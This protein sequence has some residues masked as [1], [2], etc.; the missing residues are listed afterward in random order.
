MTQSAPPPG[1]TLAARI[2]QARARFVAMATTYGLGVFN[3]NFFKQAAMLL[4]VGAGQTELQ[5]YS[6]V[7]FTLPFILFAAPA[8]WLADRFAKRRVVIGSK[9]LELAAMV[10]GAAGIVTG[11]WWLIFIMLG[12]MGL[13]S[14]IFSPALNG[15]IPELYPSE[16]VT[17]ANAML[18]L[19]VTIAILAGVASA[20][21][22]LDRAGT[23]LWGVGLG[24]LTVA[25]VVVAVSLVGLLVSLGVPARPAA[26]PR[27]AFPWSGPLI[28]FRTLRDAAR[29]PL[30]ATTISASVFI[31]FLGSLE[32]LLINPLGMQQFGLGTA[33][34]SYL[35]A[36][37]LIGIGV[38]GVISARVAVGERWHRVIGPA[39]ALVAACM[40]ALAA[41]PALPEGARVAALFALVGGVGIAGGVFLIPV[42][43][44]IQVRP[45]AEKKGAVLAATN[46]GVFIGI[47]LSGL[48]SNALLAV[49]LPTAG[50]GLAG[51][52]TLLATGVLAAA[53][54]RAEGRP[55]LL[56]R[57]LTQL[58]RGLLRL[59]YRIR[60][61]GLEAVAARGEGPILFL[62]NH[63]ALI[64]PVIVMLEL[65]PRFAPR[66]LADRDQVDRFLVRR[67]ADRFGVRPMA[68][69]GRYGAAAREDV[70][71]A[72][73]ACAADL[74]A[75]RNLILYPAGRIYRSCREDLGG[76]SALETLLGSVPDVRVVLVRTR[77][78]WGSRFSR[79]WGRHPDMV[80]GMLHG[81]KVLLANA[82]FFAPRRPVRIE[83]HEPADLPRGADRTVLNRYLEGFYNTDATPNTYVP[84]Y[85]WERGGVRALPDP[86]P[87]RLTGTVADAP[88]A[89][90]EIVLRHLQELTGVAAIRPEDLLARDLGLDSLAQVD[91]AAWLEREFGHTVE[92][93][94]A[95][96]S[97]KDVILAACGQVTAAGPAELAPIPAGWFAG[98]SDGERITLPAGR[99][100]A[101]VFLAQARRAPGR[102]AIA[103]QTRGARTYRDL[104]TAVQVL[105]PAIAALPG[106]AV[107][108]MLPAS[109]G[110]AVLYLAT[111]FAGKTPVMVNWT[112]GPRQMAHSLDL[113]GVRRVLTAGRLV[114][115]VQAQG[116][117]LSAI[118]DRLVLLEEV[119]KSISLGAK[120][121]AA[122]RAR[123]G[124]HGLDRIVPQDPAVILFTSGSENLPKAVPLTHANILTNIRDVVSHFELA[125]GD[126]ALGILPPFHSFGLTVTTLLPLL[127]G[128]RVVYHSNPTEGADLARLIA[129]YQV[130]LLVG[131][132][133]FLNGIVRNADDAQLA[134]LRAVI[135][136]AEKCPDELFAEVARRWPGLNIVEGYGITECSPVVAA[137]DERAPRRG[138][139]GKPLPSVEHVVVDLETNARIPPGAGR[140]GMLLVRGPSV[141]GGYLGD[142]VAS[143]FV[144]FEGRAWYRTGDLV[145]E[146]ADGVLAF[147]GRLKRFAKLGGEM[148]SLPAVEEVLLKGLAPGAD[149]PVVAVECTPAETNPELVLFTT[150]AVDRETANRCIRDAGLSPLHNVRRVVRLEAIPLLGTGKTD[151]RS[152]RE[153]LRSES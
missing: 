131:T 77:G 136:G 86:A 35:I 128:L 125:P 45:P 70:A 94:E 8:G 53:Y 25:G 50:F 2:R 27:A 90:R 137:N 11:N 78:L 151:Y 121:A 34:T 42:E 62:P 111:L 72:L 97:V 107:G 123:F 126:K 19:F 127:T 139:I 108:I 9:A 117:D 91:L 55:T 140:A 48:V 95:L 13:Q 80:S 29:D 17:R 59:R 98:A 149:E 110:A 100:I 96:R 129:A 4:A 119:G 133:T 44:F 60:V 146:A 152:L 57:A 81:L 52:V 31:W 114:Q 102:V 92:Q 104:L 124:W 99:H 30:L 71:A 93:A 87:P 28:S 68:D 76:T 83:L 103:D 22:A 63:P 85:R 120:V 43:S 148:I 54:R 150:L 88:P 143:P 105:R 41:V 37:Q 132:P 32:I 141:F 101:E 138:A 66:S 14:T 75:G 46:F 79:A 23:G 21:L 10:A 135:S 7:I 40:F 1:A 65:F 82:L 113:A 18:R 142:G 130:T 38:G 84:Y 24:Q 3:D 134:T 64:D 51:A 5:G 26:D 115:R 144:E 118:Q 109:A 6:L 15:S 116:L 39:G 12:L 20:G 74:G 112:T 122:V 33:V 47:L 56:T 145:V 153:M 89:T 49:A 36:T 147:R 58:G 106:E 16:Y 69:P 61:E 73:D 67:L